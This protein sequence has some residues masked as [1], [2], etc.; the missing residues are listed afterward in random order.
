MDTK[1]ALYYAAIAIGVLIAVSVV[2]SVVSAILSLAWAVISTAVT[3]AVLFGIVYVAYRAG[4]WL[5]GDGGGDPTS[6]DSVGGSR[7]TS[8][9]TSTDR[10]ERLRRRYVEGEIDEAEFERRIASELETED[11]DD[12]ERELERER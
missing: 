9:E 11:L 6:I 12:I 5:S 3:L 7:S 10:Q 8:T 1:R 2:V 4:S